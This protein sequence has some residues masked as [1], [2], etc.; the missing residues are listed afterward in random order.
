MIGSYRAPACAGRWRAS[1]WPS[2]P[3]RQWSRAA[4]PC[5]RPRCRRPRMRIEWPP[6][7]ASGC[8]TTGWSSTSFTS[9]T[10]VCRVPASADGFR[11]PGAWRADGRSFRWDRSRLRLVIADWW[12]SPAA[13]ASSRSSSPERRKVYGTSGWSE[14][15]RRISRQW[16]SGWRG[17]MT[18]VW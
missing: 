4:G 12:L 11:A 10:A 3:P 6:M 5:R 16:L 9:T 14:A 1:R 2:R 18:N 8:T 7:P 13:A 15:M 17:G